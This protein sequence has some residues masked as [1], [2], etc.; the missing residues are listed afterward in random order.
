MFPITIAEAIVGAAVG[1]MV[2][3]N[4]VIL[5]GIDSGYESS[6]TDVLA[7]SRFG[8]LIV[9]AAC[10]R[11]HRRWAVRLERECEQIGVSS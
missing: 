2:S 3:V 1:A 5:S 10:S 9:I 11:T 6:L 4:P 7:Y 8:G